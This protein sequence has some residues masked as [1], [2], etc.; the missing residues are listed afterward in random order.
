MGSMLLIDCVRARQF[1]LYL[2]VTPVSRQYQD[3]GQPPGPRLA[4]GGKQLF[5]VGASLWGFACEADRDRPIRDSGY[6]HALRVY[7]DRG[8]GALRLEAAVLE[9]EMRE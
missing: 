8:T 5:R 6:K 2:F 4:W 1:S 3:L 7:H 9:G